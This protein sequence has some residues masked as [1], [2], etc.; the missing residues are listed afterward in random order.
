MKKNDC[1]HCICVIEGNN[2][3]WVCEEL[4]KPIKD[5]DECPEQG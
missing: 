5:I 1:R 2:K 3:E 4:N